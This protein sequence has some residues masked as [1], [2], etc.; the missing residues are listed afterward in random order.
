MLM[1]KTN[2]SREMIN[3]SPEKKRLLIKLL[4][5]FKIDILPPR[6]GGFAVIENVLDPIHESSMKD[7][8]NYAIT[9]SKDKLR[10]IHDHNSKIKSR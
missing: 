4:D 9:E 2:T 3:I 1:L 10:V 8:L 6:F 5:K 7:Y